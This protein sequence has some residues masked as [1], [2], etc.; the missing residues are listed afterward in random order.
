MDPLTHALSGVAIKQ[1]GFSR[2][3][4]LVIAVIASLLPDIDYVLRFLGTDVLLRYHRG[5]THGVFALFAVPLVLALIFKEKC[6]F[7]YAFSLS[8][9]CYGLHILFDLTNQYGTRVLSPLDWNQYALDI[10]FIIEPW[11]TIPLLL[12]FLAG[13]INKRRAR[14]VAISTLALITIVIGSRYYLQGE[15]KSLLKRHIDANIYKV[16]PLPNDFLTWSFLTKTSEGVS[17]G[18]VDLFSQRV[19][20]VESF[21]KPQT[22]RLIEASKE[23]D[24]VQNFLYFAKFPYA[25][26]IR[27]D[28]KVTVLWRELA[29]AYIGRG[30]FT[31]TVEFDKNHNIKDAKFRF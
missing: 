12:S 21:N 31:V 19:T 2:R 14:L 13:I 5:I 29:Y 18:L 17:I 22:D 25:E 6:R 7:L 28:D 27:T 3:G 16:Y 23:S 8:F 9:I 1:A 20:T 30:P 10:N 11:I 24:V 4:A 15:A 26:V